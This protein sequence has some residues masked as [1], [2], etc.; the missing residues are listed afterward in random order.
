[1]GVDAAKT[2]SW[3]SLQSCWLSL[4]ASSWEVEPRRPKAFMSLNTVVVSTMY[5]RVARFLRP[6]QPFFSSSLQGGNLVD[7]LLDGGRDELA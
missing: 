2:S 7:E 5:F 1:M 4:R 3:G 6:L